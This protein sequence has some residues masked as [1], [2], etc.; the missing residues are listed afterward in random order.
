MMTSLGLDYETLKEINPDLIMTSISN[1]GQWGPYRDYSAQELNLYAIGGLMHITGEPSREP[2]Q[3][4][5]QAGA[6]RNGPER[7]RRD[8]YGPLA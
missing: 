4:G 3:V 1:F 5:A 6:I 7:L 8:P 2:L